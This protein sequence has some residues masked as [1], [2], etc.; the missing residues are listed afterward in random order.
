MDAV[1]RRRVLAFCAAAAVVSVTTRAWGQVNTPSSARVT[2]TVLDTA[3]RPLAGAVVELIGF[4]QTRTNASGLFRFAAVPAGTAV[5]HVAKIGLRPVT[6]VM[7]L[8]A[9]DSVDLDVTLGLAAQ[10]LPTVVVY[11]SSDIAPDLTGFDRRRRNGMGHYI[12]AD[13]VAQSHATETAELLRTLPGLSINARG[14]VRSLRGK[15][16]FIGTSCPDEGV[17]VLIDGVVMAADHNALTS[18]ETGFDINTIP[19]A[20][21]RGIEVYLSPATTPQE[22]VTSRSSVCGTIAIWT[23]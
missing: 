9:G 8:A 14:Q 2:G 1:A 12:T 20:V 6:G 18:T 21:I 10:E 4:G 22:L 16:N 7:D 19:P 3:Q 15:N 13:D 11:D 17:V 5:L 23:H